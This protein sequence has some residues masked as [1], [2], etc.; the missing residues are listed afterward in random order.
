MSAPASAEA[1]R[2]GAVPGDHGVTFG[3]LPAGVDTDGILARAF[4]A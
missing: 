1:A 3:T 2:P 4:P